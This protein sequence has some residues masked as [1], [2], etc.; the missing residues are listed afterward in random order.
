MFAAAGSLGHGKARS[1][2]PYLD[3]IDN[4]PGWGSTPTPQWSG[5][6][7]ASAAEPGTMLH[8]WFAA[9]S[10]NKCAVE[11][12]GCPVVL[13]LN[14]GPGASSIL[15]MLTEQGPLIIDNG[16]K[17]MENPYAWTT[18][19]NLLIVESPAGVG[20]SYCDAMLTG[21][22]CKN[23]DISTAKALHAGLLDFFRK[24]P[25]LTASKFFI[26]GESYAGVYCPTLAAE[27]VAGNAKGGQPHINLTGMAVGDPCTDNDSQRQSMDMLWYAH[28]NALL[29]DDDYNFLTTQCGA[30]HLSSRASGK[31]VAQH[32]LDKSGNGNGNGNGRTRVGSA[33][34]RRPRLSATGKQSAN[35]TA[36]FRRYMVASSKGVSQNWE[37]AFVNELSL[38][39]P[40]AQFRFDIPGT[41][42][43]NTAQWMMSS[44]VK[45]AL[46]VDTAPVKAWPG[47]TAGWSYTSSY[48]ACN[49]AAPAGTKSMID[50]YR[51][52][53]PKLPGKI[54]VY[55]GDTDP[56]VSYE[57][58]RNAIAKV[59][60]KVVS[61]YRPWFFNFTAATPDFLAKKDLLFGPSL[62]PEAGGAQFGGEIVDY[63]HDLSF[64]TVHGS[65]HMVPTFRPRAA[66]QLIEHVVSDSAFAPPVPDDASLAAM[67][68]DAFDKFLD[69]WVDKAESPAFVR[70]QG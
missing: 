53:A 37:R 34:T 65:G 16:G 64:A 60:F 55:N 66:L 61:P 27:I 31:W 52:L 35:C 21:G 6:L 56:C 46:H 54:V 45:K 51:D 50:F 38:F 15:G 9:S 13:W 14:G 69:A 5:F 47:P 68:D 4:L 41:L 20:Y 8:Y 48:A 62:S 43:Y 25:A 23:D 30:S 40:R 42:N 12:G 24:F 58:T 59:G 26:T 70:T 10:S 32:V 57:G 11:G 49:D 39:S 22:S 17:L 28:K 7:N 33:T 36:A 63:E 1:L 44:A 3:Y 29:P 2:G 18:V 19:A 67:A